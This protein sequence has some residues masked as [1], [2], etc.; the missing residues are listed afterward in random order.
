MMNRIHIIDCY[1]WIW[2]QS[3]I[4]NERCLWLWDPNA[5]VNYGKI[6]SFRDTEEWGPFRPAVA[7]RSPITCDTS[8]VYHSII[9]LR[10][11]TVITGLAYTEAPSYMYMPANVLHLD[12]AFLMSESA[13]QT[14]LL[15]L[16]T[17]SRMKLLQAL[18]L[19]VKRLKECLKLK[20]LSMKLRRNRAWCAHVQIMWVAGADPGDGPSCAK[21]NGG[22]GKERKNRKGERE[23]ET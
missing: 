22:K 23:R 21:K 4:D 19:L 8:L 12:R 13:F 18:H 7:I 9:S 1:Y 17:C 10:I 15:K 5:N 16:F 20:P 14:P 11:S 3:A 2:I 6:F